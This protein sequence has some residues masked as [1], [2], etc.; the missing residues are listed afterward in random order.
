[1]T[2]KHQQLLN[3]IEEIPVGSK[4][5]VRKI[6]RQLKV[7]EGTAYRAIKEAE[8]QGLL[9]TIQRVGTIR[10]EP[11]QDP[12]I[13]TLTFSEVLNIAEGTILGGQSGLENSLQ[14]FVIGAMKIDA[15]E[16]YISED[17][18]MIV[19]NRE[20]VQRL[21]LEK[22]AAVLIT[23]G[24]NTS[25]SIVQLANRL[26]LP[27]MSTTYD[28]FTVATMINRAITDQLIQKEIL[29]I[30]SIYTPV[31]QTMYLYETD[32]VADYKKLNGQSQ[33]ARFPVVDKHERVIGIVSPKDIIHKDNDMGIFEVMTLHPVTVETTTNVAAAS[34]MM[35]WEGYELL[36]VVDSHSVLKGVVSRQDVMK[37]MQSIQQQSQMSNT[38]SDQINQTIDR[39]SK[40]EYLFKLTPQMSSFLGTISVGVLS[41][42]VARIVHEYILPQ[43]KNHY[44]IEESSIQYLHLVQI[45]QELTLL[46]H[47]YHESRRSIHLDIDIY[48]GNQLVAKSFVTCQLFSQNI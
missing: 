25:P 17:S 5:S 44:M 48:A 9:K 35:I 13:E 23:G 45:D 46:P 39:K 20:N 43:R 38:I 29:Q 19:G 1:M 3:Y 16:R 21:A 18:L 27:V 40:D 11:P 4:L 6:A 42:A 30:K 34:H 8:N 22:G 33:H 12:T 26:N 7:S 36:P 15:M 32:T 24:F 14:K 28:T 37:A 31:D 41:E 10:T 47:I 2:T